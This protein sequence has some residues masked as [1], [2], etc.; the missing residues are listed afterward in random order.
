MQTVYC[1][2]IAI[3]LVAEQAVKVGVGEVGV[4]ETFQSQ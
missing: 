2:V 3:V 1:S 4:G